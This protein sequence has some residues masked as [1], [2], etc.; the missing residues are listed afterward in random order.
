MTAATI[1]DAIVI[2]VRGTTMA[3]SDWL[4]DAQMRHGQQK[5]PDNS[6][7]SF[8]PDSSQL[9]H[10]SGVKELSTRHLA[11]QPGLLNGWAKETES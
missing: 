11:L 1:D 9:R 8:I 2:A 4:M 5:G 6:R 3:P 7:L 10:M